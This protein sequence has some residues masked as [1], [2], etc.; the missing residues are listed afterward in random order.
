M[1]QIMTQRLFCCRGPREARKAV[2]A[3]N[4]ALG[5]TLLAVA[6]GLSLYA[7]YQQ[8][9]LGPADATF[10]QAK[11]DRIFPFFIVHELPP[12]VVGIIIA[13]IFAAAI[14]SLDSTLIALSQVVVTGFY[15]PWRQRRAAAGLSGVSTLSADAA[16]P[17][18]DERVELRLSKILVVFWGVALSGMAT[19]AIGLYGRYGA[20]LPLA[21][22]MATYASGPLLATFLLAFLRVNVDARGIVWGAPFAVVA[23]FGLQWHTP[24][25]QAVA[26]GLAAVLAGAW[27]WREWRAARRADAAG[28]P[29]LGW[30]AQVVLVVAAVAV[31]SVFTLLKLP[32]GATGDWSHLNVCYLWNV[33]IGLLIGLALGYGL[34]RRRAAT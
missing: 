15:R 13:G 20:I 6:V 22:A 25:A 2:I 7:F 4:A 3:S 16:S 33:P 27:A 9:P 19:L 21:L 32:Q 8:H 5:I 12:G 30:S 28:P 10:V 11:S 23:V 26:I 29:V 18:V 24:W 34:A 17:G 31:V 14:S 1:D